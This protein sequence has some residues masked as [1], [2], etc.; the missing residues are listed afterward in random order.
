MS[1]LISLAAAGLAALLCYGRVRRLAAQ[2]P[3]LRRPNPRGRAA[4][5]AIAAA[6]TVL[7][8]GWLLTR[9]TTPAPWYVW[10]A[11]SLLAIAISLAQF[12]KSVRARRA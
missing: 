11:F 2:P 3:P 8:V 5:E 4:A 7:L 6:L 9:A 10:P 12:R 1:S